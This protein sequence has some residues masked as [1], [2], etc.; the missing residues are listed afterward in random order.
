MPGSRLNVDPS[1]K[2]LVVCSVSGALRCVTYESGSERDGMVRIDPFLN[3]QTADIPM[4]LLARDAG[5]T[6]LVNAGDEPAT[7]WVLAIIVKD[8]E[9]D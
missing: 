7:A 2:M 8:T 3:D 6:I 5:G 1:T 4:L 9:G